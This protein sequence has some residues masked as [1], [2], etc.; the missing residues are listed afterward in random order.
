VTFKPDAVNDGLAFVGREYERILPRHYEGDIEGAALGYA[1]DVQGDGNDIVVVTQVRYIS[2]DPH[3]GAGRVAQVDRRG[4]L[5]GDIENGHIV[6]RGGICRI[7][8]GVAVR[9]GLEGDDGNCDTT[10]ERLGGTA[11]R[12]LTGA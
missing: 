2:A 5:Y 6:I 7:G 1:G 10:T 12:I 9:V 8:D 3:I 11:D 4:A